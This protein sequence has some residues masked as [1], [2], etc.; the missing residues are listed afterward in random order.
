MACQ[1]MP[2]TRKAMAGLTRSIAD[3]IFIGLL[4]LIFAPISGFLIFIRWVAEHF[5]EQPAGQGDWVLSLLLNVF[6]EGAVVVFAGSVL[7][8]I[9]AIWT[10]EWIE[11][12]L[13]RVKLHFV[14]VLFV[15]GAV[16][17]GMMIFSS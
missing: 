9:W 14:I 13:H 7:G 12:L 16:T 17:L 4:C 8:I 10:P 6:F 5:P 11:R 3:R 1:R 15:F 2:A